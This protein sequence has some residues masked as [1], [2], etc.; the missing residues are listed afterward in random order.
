MIIVRDHD[1]W[2]DEADTAVFSLAAP[3]SVLSC[4]PKIPTRRDGDRASYQ[5]VV[6]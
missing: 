2:T 5:P 6:G 3:T 1:A 4:T